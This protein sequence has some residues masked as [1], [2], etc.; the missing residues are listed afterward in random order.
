MVLLVQVSVVAGVALALESRAT[1]VPG[2]RAPVMRLVPLALLLLP[3]LRWALPSAAA[4]VIDL[5]HGPFLAPVADAL[6]I[7]TMEWVIIAVWLSVSSLLL[8]RILRGIWALS[9]ALRDARPIVDIAQI[10]ELE[11]ARVAVGLSAPLPEL[12]LARHVSSPAVFG[13]RRPV[14]LVPAWFQDASS[15]ARFAM[16][17]HELEHIKNGDWAQQLLSHIVRALYWPVPL[18]GM[19]ARRAVLSREILADHAVVRAG[20]QP[21]VYAQHLITAAR[22]CL[23]TSMPAVVALHAG[24][25]GQLAHRVALLLQSPRTA[26]AAPFAPL[27]LLIVVVGL[28]VVNPVRCT[29]A[30]GGDAPAAQPCP[31]GLQA[32]R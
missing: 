4:P 6:P 23:A 14:V 27:A 25:G 20:I 11:R 3:L 2:R 17:C 9:R 13:W 31:D 32:P 21:T 18:V 29:A 15:D 12:L 24:G 7:L 8:L 30:S 22:A 28:A 10:A 26:S 16:L 19:W 1:R 5:S